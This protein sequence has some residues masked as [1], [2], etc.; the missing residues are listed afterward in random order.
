[1]KDSFDQQRTALPPA[2][3]GY[4]RAEAPAGTVHKVG[5]ARRS[6]G[7]A[8]ISGWRLLA[9]PMVR[10]LRAILRRHQEE[11]NPRDDGRCS[12]RMT[13]VLPREITEAGRG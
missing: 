10:G 4:K 12:I 2:W 6:A 13:A 11:A 1:M 3:V 8:A 9:L 7:L 5:G